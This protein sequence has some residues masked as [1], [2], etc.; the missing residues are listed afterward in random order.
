[1]F[2]VS[3]I[4]K[5][6]NEDL[7]NQIV[8]VMFNGQ[9]LYL[10]MNN[11]LSQNKIDFNKLSSDLSAK[12][13]KNGVNEIV[14]HIGYEDAFDD[15]ANTNSQESTEAA[16]EQPMMKRSGSG[17]KRYSTVINKFPFRIGRK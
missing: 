3:F 7:T 9:W 4:F 8:C 12:L 5:V 14:N 11:Y 16:Q 6:G 2:Y 1:M 17:I 15:D 10:N 13:S